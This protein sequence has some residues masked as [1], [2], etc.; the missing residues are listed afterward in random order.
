MQLPLNIGKYRIDKELGRGAMGVVY[1][2]IDESLD[3][4]IAVKVLAKDFFSDPQQVSRFTQEA[5]IVAKL[6]HPNI[7]KIYAIEKAMDA[8]WII[9]EYLRGNILA[10]I[11]KQN[12]ALPVDRCIKLVEQLASALGYAHSRGII[13]RDIKPANV[14]ITPEDTV[15]LMDFGIARDTESDMNLTRTG[16][17]IGTPRYMSPEQFKGHGVDHCSDV[18]SL[19]IMAYE[20]ISGEVPFSGKNIMEYAYKHFN[21][22]P[23]PIR[24][25]VPSIPVTF[26]QFIMKSISKKKEDRPQNLSNISFSSFEADTVM[27][28]APLGGFDRLFLKKM[29]F[30]LCGIFLFFLILFFVF[31][32]SSPV[33]TLSPDETSVSVNTP[34]VVQNQLSEVK[35]P[36]QPSVP[37]IIE[38]PPAPVPALV[39]HEPSTFYQAEK[40]SHPVQPAQIEEEKRIEQPP[41]AQETSFQ[42]SEP[43]VEPSPPKSSEPVVETQPTDLETGEVSQEQSGEPAPAEETEASEESVPEVPEEEQPPVSESIQEQKAAPEEMK[44]PETKP[45]PP[46][47]EK[48]FY[49]KT[50]G[51]DKGLTPW[52]EAPPPSPSDQIVNPEVIQE[53][54]PVTQQTETPTPP[55]R[56]SEILSALSR[57]DYTTIRALVTRKVKNG[58]CKGE[59][60]SDVG[61]VLEH[62]MKN[63]NEDKIAVDAINWCSKAIGKSGNK[64][65]VPLL[66]KLEKANVHKRIQSYASSAIRMIY[67]ETGQTMGSYEKNL[68]GRLKS[69]EWSVIRNAAKEM[70]KNDQFS[71]LLLGQL[72]SVLEKYRKKPSEEKMAVDAICYSLAVFGKA[73]NQKYLPFLKKFEKGKLPRKVKSYV[74]EAIADIEG[75]FHIPFFPKIGK[76]D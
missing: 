58:K 2:G 12:G 70:I 7:M 9:M 19:G 33:R 10:D 37:V 47:E 74:S 29:I 56:K 41:P 43:S 26:E 13:H 25:K 59:F 15:K 36:E 71:P 31:K 11:L 24:K 67:E 54:Q 50:E 6:D 61:H 62:Y 27:V 73:K 34:P 16:T 64:G 55:V 14:M 8:T 68:L 18:Y 5:K 75:G 65:Y 45:E 35:T 28:H 1:F 49:V 4:D 22:T 38:K 32:K 57:E 63:P 51:M 48:I 42:E 39:F 52:S 30:S 72:Q 76:K 53:I 23:E 69:G 21:H 40:T 60:L 44:V 3:R 17:I 20:M 46:Q 66:K